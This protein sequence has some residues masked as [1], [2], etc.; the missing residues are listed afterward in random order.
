MRQARQPDR[1][2]H[3]EFLDGPHFTFHFTVSKAPVLLYITPRHT[4]HPTRPRR[5]SPRYIDDINLRDRPAVNC[6]CTLPTMATAEDTMSVLEIEN[7]IILVTEILRTAD[8]HN[9]PYYNAILQESRRAL[10]EAKR[11]ASSTIAGPSGTSSAYQGDT[12]PWEDLSG[13]AHCWE[14]AN[15]RKHSL[16][17][18]EMPDSK[19]V[20]GQP[21]P[22]S[23]DSPVELTQWN[24]PNRA[25][26][27]TV[28]II[29]L[30]DSYPPSPDPF[31]ELDN[32]YRS[33]ADHTRS[34]PADAF[35]QEWMQIDE[36]AQFMMQPTTPG[37][38]FALQPHQQPPKVKT[39]DIYNQQVPY[40]PGPDPMPWDSPAT[41]SEEYGEFPLSGAEAD[42]IEK[43]FEN[44]KDHGET[45]EDR[46][47]T[48]RI[49]SSTLK[50]YQKI[51]LTWLLKME[52]GSSK[53]GILAD[54]MGLGKTVSHLLCNH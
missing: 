43:L 20:S 35:N 27:N 3:C 13:P 48:P 18:A 14:I 47:P 40:F 12:P 41:D 29:D 42:A 25:S 26:Y 49:M 36:L 46:E 17:S 16:A 45:P 19:R 34:A 28:P 1:S 4:V 21:S 5:L 44:I 7:N 23:P 2:L 30:T 22:T 8:E 50:E 33:E 9:V 24:L 31:A 11:T 10:A 51:G 38:G 53:G 39:T 6:A 52:R 54:E 37:A 32:A 15:T